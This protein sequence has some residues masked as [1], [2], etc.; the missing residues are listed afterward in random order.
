MG[1]KISFMPKYFRDF[2]IENRAFKQIE[3]AKASP[4][5]LAMSPRHP[6]T[7]ELF[8]QKESNFKIIYHFIF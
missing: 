4:K 6:S 7:V 3:K 5:P 2:N 1:N 8:K